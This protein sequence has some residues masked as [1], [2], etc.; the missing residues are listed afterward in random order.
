VEVDVGEVVVGDAGHARGAAV[1]RLARKLCHEVL[2]LMPV[3]LR[4]AL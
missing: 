1:V 2:H 4:D 3:L